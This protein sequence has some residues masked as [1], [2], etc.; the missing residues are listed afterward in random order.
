MTEPQNVQREY[1]RERS[2]RE[3]TCTATRKE[4]AKQECV[5]QTIFLSLQNGKSLDL[6]DEASGRV[7]RVQNSAERRERTKKGETGSF[8]SSVF[9]FCL[10]PVL[11]DDSGLGK[12][13]PER[14]V[15]A[16]T[17]IH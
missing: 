16:W 6:V 8:F 4:F 17:K 1:I 13:T 11:G 7:K 5:L 12:I 14:D 15:Y 9:F 3:L 2:E 10:M